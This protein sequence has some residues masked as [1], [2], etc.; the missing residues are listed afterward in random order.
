MAGRRGVYQPQTSDDRG[1]GPYICVIRR[2]SHGSYNIYH[3]AHAMDWRQMEVTIGGEAVVASATVVARLGYEFCTVAV[4][5]LTHWLITLCH[6]PI[7][8]T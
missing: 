4:R 2:K 6:L 8:F 7:L 3:G 5:S 1:Q